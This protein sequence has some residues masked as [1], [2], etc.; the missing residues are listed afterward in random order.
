MPESLTESF[1]ATDAV[2][3]CS[4]DCAVN[5][6]ITIM[7]DAFNKVHRV[8]GAYRA[9][10]T[11][12][13]SSLTRASIGGGASVGGAGAVEDSPRTRAA[14]SRVDTSG[15]GGALVDFAASAH[16]SA[17]GGRS[18]SGDTDNP[19]AAASS[20]AADSGAGGRAGEDVA[21]ALALELLQTQRA[22]LLRTREEMALNLETLDEELQRLDERAQ[23]MGMLVRDAGEE[24][25]EQEQQGEGPP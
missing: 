10:L 15:G 13:S 22:V 20:S 2:L 12:G 18:D 11:R 25:E 23:A 3:E 8:G 17:D 24:E 5:V 1:R 6:F 9:S 16:S 19:L 21:S 4:A 14:R 7:A